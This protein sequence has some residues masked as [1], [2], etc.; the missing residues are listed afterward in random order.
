MRTSVF[1]LLSLYEWS[2]IIGLNPYWTAQ[3]GRDV[4]ERGSVNNVK[5]DSVLFQ[6]PYQAYDFLGREEIAESIQQAE[7]LFAQVTGFYPAPKYLAGEP[8]QYS[9]HYNRQFPIRYGMRSASG[10][11]KSTQ[12]KYGKIQVMGI[13]SLT[14]IG[15]FAVVLSDATGSGIND[16][17]TVTAAVPAGT[18]AAEIAAFFIETDR[19]NLS[20][21]E[22]EIKPL[23]VSVVGAVATI[24]GHV[25]LLVLPELQLKVAPDELSALDNTIYA[26]EITVYTR[27]TD[28]TD[29]G[30]LRWL[31]I[32]P[33]EQPPCE[34]EISTACFGIQDQELGYVYPLPAEW[35]A[36]TE[37]FD[38]NYP[39]CVGRDPDKLT[40][41]YLAGVERQSNGRMNA[42]CAKIIALLATSLLPNR[43][44]GCDRANQRLWYYRS[45]PTDDKS[46]LL[47]PRQTMEKAGNV[48]GSMGRGACEAFMLM[49]S[50]IQFGSP[51]FG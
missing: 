13:E 45:L 19:V 3:I 43:T 44:A 17:F 26:A 5:C 11:F 34:V 9:Q 24:T 7:E 18:S 20:L 23:N 36:T 21:A 48:L 37:Q 33:C 14:E 1:T 39:C 25:S 16:T 42:R 41:N 50:M 10:K 8:H 31:N 38:L 4:P 28:I 51:S 29:T 35:N 27:A 6:S 2:Q 46:N 49:E 32:F 15:D 47:I 40:V 12:T 22:S 30:S